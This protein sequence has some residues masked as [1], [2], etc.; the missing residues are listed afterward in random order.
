VT[1]RQKDGPF[2]GVKSGPPQDPT[3]PIV[4]TKEID[5]IGTPLAD[6]PKTKS[7]EAKD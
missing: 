5:P 7:G 1:Q 4:D 2:E 6:A 3:K